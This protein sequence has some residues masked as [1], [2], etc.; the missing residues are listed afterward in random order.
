MDV[1]SPVAVIEPYLSNLRVVVV[2]AVEPGFGGQEFLDQ[3]VEHARKLAD[4]RL[5]KGLKFKICAD[6]G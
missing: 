4:L 1:H 5:W 6:G 2:M 3:A